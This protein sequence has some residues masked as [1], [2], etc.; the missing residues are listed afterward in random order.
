MNNPIIE[1][2]ILTYFKPVGSVRFSK[3]VNFD[4]FIYLFIF[5]TALAFYYFLYYFIT[6]QVIHRVAFIFPS[7]KTCIDFKPLQIYIFICAVDFNYK[8]NL[9][10]KVWVIPSV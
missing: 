7:G 2:N 8:N 4:L 10:I 6:L 3:V 9:I 1:T 5:T